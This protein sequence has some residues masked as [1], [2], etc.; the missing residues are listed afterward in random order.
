MSQTSFKAELAK[1]KALLLQRLYEDAFEEEGYPVSSFENLEE[2]ENWEI[3]VYADTD[4]AHDVHTKMQQLAKDNGITVEFNRED[5]SPDIDW[6]AQTLRE[7]VPVRAGRFIVHGSHDRHIPK[8]HEIAVEVDAGLAFGTGHHG[9]TAG[10]LEMLNEALKARKFYNVLDLG[11]GSGVLAIAAAKAMPAH[12][13]ATDIDPVS[14][15]TTIANAKKNGVQSRIE[16]LTAAGFGHYRMAQQAPF[17][18]IIANI[19]ARPLQA[20]AH[21]IC[22]ATASGG[23]VILSGLLPHQRAPLVASFRL[24]GLH[25][26]YAH[27]SDGWLVLVFDKP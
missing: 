17:D 13:L 6:V 21:D 5:L 2:P 3:A 8:S 7:L 14:T 26:N 18:L 16:C 15:Q 1:D 10:C 22:H 24:Q 27:I 4:V 19:L 20:M 9:T 11:T 12:I 23:M 25:L